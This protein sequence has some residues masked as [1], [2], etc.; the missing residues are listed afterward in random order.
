MSMD[1]RAVTEGEPGAATERAALVR[2]LIEQE[3]ARGRIEAAI[4]GRTKSGPAPLSF[5]QERLW[6]LEKLGIAGTTYNSSIALQLRGKLDRRALQLAVAQIANRQQIL[7]TRIEVIDGIG[8]QVVDPVGGSEIRY[9]D[10]TRTPGAIAD[11][12]VT[13]LCSAESSRPFDFAHEHLLRLMLLQL[14]D[15]HHVLLMTTHHIVADAWSGAIL[16]SELVQ[17][18]T[19]NVRG[20]STTLPALLL[21]YADYALWQ[22]ELLRDGALHSQ[23]LYWREQLAGAPA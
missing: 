12:V 20:V 4:I 19:A 16:T 3:A 22:R 5:P 11:G 13:R 1:E 2:L 23:L 8:V 17:L 10:L 6:A 18:Y 21:Q 9:V 14:A 7:R 15:E